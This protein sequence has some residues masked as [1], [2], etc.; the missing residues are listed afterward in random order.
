MQEQ[1]GA[2]HQWLHK[3]VGRWTIESEFRMGPDEPAT[4]MTS[5][6]VVR[7]LGGLWVLG[8]GTMGEGQG[9]DASVMTLGYDPR[10]RCFV[11]TFVASCMTHLWPY[12]GTL[13]ATGKVLTL[14]S[15]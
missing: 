12:K 4:T 8:E 5:T 13:D 1:P 15:E 14:D 10:G 3:L 11:G 9:A 2:E 6:E 7:P